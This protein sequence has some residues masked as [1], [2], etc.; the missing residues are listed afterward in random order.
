MRRAVTLLALAVAGCNGSGLGP[1]DVELTINVQAAVTDAD[2]ASVR[3]LDIAAL[4]TNMAV[5]T[6]PLSRPLARTERIA[7]HFPAAMGHVTVSVLARDDQQGVVMRGVTGDI[8]LELG[9]GPHP[10]SVQL[11]PPQTGAHA[12]SGIQLAPP[13]Y[14]MFTGQTLQI[15][16]LG[17]EMVTW[18]ASDGGSIDDQGV[19]T[20]P[21]TA[22]TF[23]AVATSL[24]YP[25]DHASATLNV[26]ANGITVY[27]GQLG[28]IGSVD[29]TGSDARVNQPWGSVLAGSILYFTDGGQEVRKADL[30]TGEVSTI[31]GSPDRAFT[32]DGTGAAANF[33]GPTG[34]AFDGN[35]TLYVAEIC[36][37]GIRTVDTI[38]GKTTTLAGTVGMYGT[39]D[40][41]GAAAQFRAPLGLA[42]DAANHLLYLGEDQSQLIRTIDVTTGVVTT[43]AGTANTAGFADGPAAMAKFNDPMNLVL[44]G[45]ALYIYDARNLKVR[46]LDLGAKTV[47]TVASNV[48]ASSMGSAGPGKVSL[49]NPL[50]TLDLASG[51]ITPLLNGQNQ[52]IYDWYNSVTA[53]ADGTFWAGAIQK[54]VHY[55]TAAAKEIVLA[56]VDHQW[57]E[58]EGPR[59]VAGISSFNN[60]TVRAA[61]G[62]IYGRDNRIW[63]LGSDGKIVNV[64]G[65][66]NGQVVGCDAG[67]AFGSD[68]MLYA[69]DRC[70]QTIVRIDVDHGGTFGVYAGKANN[71]GYA[72]GPVASALVS[73]P[74]E[75]T[76]DGNKLYFTDGNNHVIR[77]IDL[78][79]NTVSTIAG[80]PGM[81]GYL[82]M[83]GAMAKFCNP[84]G[85]AA[86][87]AGNL[88]VLD[89]NAV[90]KIVISGA[91]VSTFVANNGNG[92]VDGPS[93]TAKLWGPRA[94]T[95]DPTK[96]YLYFTENANDTIRRVEMATAIVSTVAGAP[97]KTQVAEGPLPGAI[98]QATAIHFAATG[99]LLVAVPRENSLLQIRLP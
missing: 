96:K 34:L 4:G 39:M 6:Y 31:A 61:D 85:I 11:V 81:C 70:N 86:D 57:T 30:N 28:G 92:Y 56:G 93:G 75:I 27:A 8:D 33:C 91:V 78:S 2:V 49:G 17:G 99:E 26:L 65:G 54:I 88:Y 13:T 74:N 62:T 52:M 12:P 48:A 1:K 72:D 24:T 90:R 22:G 60:F 95:F 7:V 16:I 3:S 66:S 36:A 21:A 47:S 50:R 5:M 69:L 76:A 80:T 63:R 84:Q 40:G 89:N 55:D 29:G 42:F 9:T 23:H 58:T 14:S 38:T 19:F 73:S 59:A 44:D 68:G 35:H 10:E 32:L 94:L 45:G 97:G 87:G 83:P 37:P 25:T 51:T 43:I 46:K 20:A 15:G 79:T 67:M 18:A 82:D 98:N 71:G 53:A 64:S 77:A 41:T